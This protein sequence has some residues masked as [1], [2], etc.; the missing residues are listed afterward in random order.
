MMSNWIE[1]PRIRKVPCTVDVENTAERLHAH[2]LL[3]GYDPEPGDEVIVHGAPTDVP[4]GTR[5]V[6]RCT[7]TVRPAGTV[8]YMIAKAVGYLELTELYEVG[9]SEGRPS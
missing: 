2:V 8:R 5:Q 9:F 3:D 1:L 6:V 4:F 7:A